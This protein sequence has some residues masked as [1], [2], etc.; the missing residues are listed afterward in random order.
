MSRIAGSR[1]TSRLALQGPTLHFGDF[2]LELETGHLTRLGTAV[3]IQPQPARALQ[4][5]AE[6]AG[7]L[8]TREELRTHLW[9][10]DHHVNFDQGLNFCIQQVRQALD[11]SAR[12]PTFIET[13]PRRGY[14]FLVP[15]ER[16]GADGAHEP[17]PWST[18][19][20]AS[21][22]LAILGTALS[23]AVALGVLPG[24]A[25]PP[26]RLAVLPFSPAGDQVQARLLAALVGE[27]LSG[28]LVRALPEGIGVVA[29]L[30]LGPETARRRTSELGKA[31]GSQLLLEGDVVQHG[32][33]LRV[34]VRLVR[35]ADGVHLWAGIYGMSANPEEW[36]RRFDQVAVEIAGELDGAR[37]A[38][39]GGGGDLLGA[40]RAALDGWADRV[41]M[42]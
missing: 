36:P 6:R 40:T 33:R 15:V 26:T 1:S 28:H 3:R 8:V 11:D 17:E 30:D 27:E 24:P 2:T 34:L 41:L 22:W 12:T 42:R 14:R 39:L 29:A 5:L 35:A 16:S 37:R 9:G 32:D 7:G 25:G 19:V 13:I 10:E 18:R 38:R 20:K 4:Y 21:V 31:L 23:G